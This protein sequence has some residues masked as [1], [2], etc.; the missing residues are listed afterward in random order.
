MTDRIRSRA[1][2][3]PTPRSAPTTRSSTPLFEAGLAE[4]EAR[5]RR[6]PPELRRRRVARRRRRRSRSRS[7]IDRDIAPRALRDGH[8][9]PTSTTRSPPPGAPSRPGPRRPWRERLAIIRR[10]ADL[11]QRA[12]D[13]VRGADGDRGRQEPARGAR[14]GRG[15]GRPAPLLRADDGGQRRL[16]PPDGQPRR[17]DRPHPLDPPAARRLRGHQPVQLPDGPRRRPDRR[18]R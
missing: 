15:G 18:R 5:A 16:R 13:G 4:A 8:A 10:A 7:P 3:S 12:P 2:R 9:R 17:R 14:R 6:P 1:S 11:H